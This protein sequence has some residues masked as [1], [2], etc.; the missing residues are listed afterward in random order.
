MASRAGWEIRDWLGATDFC[1]ARKAEV[2][3]RRECQD[4]HLFVNNAQAALPP[5][6]VAA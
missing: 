4:F 3:R 1:F 2:E 6:L 5:I